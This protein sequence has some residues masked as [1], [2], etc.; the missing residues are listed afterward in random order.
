MT[1][2]LGATPPDQKASHMR[3][4]LIANFAGKQGYYY[5]ARRTT[6]EWDCTRGEQA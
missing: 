3:S 5:L 2:L 6:E 4:P 1:C